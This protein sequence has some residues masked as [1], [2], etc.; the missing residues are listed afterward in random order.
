MERIPR[1]R[2]RLSARGYYGPPA[3]ESIQ[4]WIPVVFF[5]TVMFFIFVCLTFI[6]YISPS[7]EYAAADVRVQTVPSG[8]PSYLYSILPPNPEWKPL[9]TGPRPSGGIVIEK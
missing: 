2:K 4:P 1:T 8:S 6:D 9:K 3:D 7:G 5:T